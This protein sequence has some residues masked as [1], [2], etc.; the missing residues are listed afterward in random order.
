MRIQRNINRREK[1]EERSREEWWDG[2]LF[3]F[4]KIWIIAQLSYSRMT[5]VSCVSYY[6]LILSL[7]ISIFHSPS[8]FF[9]C[10]FPYYSL[11]FFS[12]SLSHTHT[13][14]LAFFLIS[15]SFSSI[16]I[17]SCY[18]SSSHS[19][20]LTFLVSFSLQQI[21]DASDRYFVQ[22]LESL[23]GIMLDPR[24]K[25]GISSMQFLV[26]FN[27]LTLPR[28]LPLSLSFSSFSVWL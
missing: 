26:L 17:I 23:L 8:L 20:S 4:I 7:I 5:V 16:L 27:P 13:Y 25:V 6:S 10:S 18:I 21:E 3:H 1:L 28:T 15:R 22:L 14:F 24:P 12:L 2:S 9:I 19:R 11:Y